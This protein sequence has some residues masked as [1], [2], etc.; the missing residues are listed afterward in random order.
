MKMEEAECYETSAQ[1]SDIGG[2]LKRKNATQFAIAACFGMFLPIF[3]ET[4]SIFVILKVDKIDIP[5]CMLRNPQRSL[6]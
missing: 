6:C 3:F 2:S 4:Q 5:D 1:N